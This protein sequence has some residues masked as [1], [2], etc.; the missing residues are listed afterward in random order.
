MRMILKR[1]SFNQFV[2]CLPFNDLQLFCRNLCQQF[3]GSAIWAIW[4]NHKFSKKIGK[5]L[6]NSFNLH[7]IFM[8]NTFF[9]F[10]KSVNWA[11]H[12][13]T[14]RPKKNVAS[15]F[16]FSLKA[17]KRAYIAT[18]D[19]VKDGGW[20]C[21]SSCSNLRAFLHGSRWPSRSYLITDRIKN[22]NFYSS[23]VNMVN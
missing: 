7:F 9:T 15:H 3:F 8:K 20:C 18:A 19:V 14:S 22:P 12:P 4:K 16:S 6:K 10:K 5:A 17:S 23:N 13:P 21:F 2:S 11:S 1:R